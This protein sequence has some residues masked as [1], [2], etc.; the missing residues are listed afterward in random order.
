MHQNDMQNFTKSVLLLS[1]L[2]LGSLT[3]TAQGFKSYLQYDDNLD[4]LKLTT[5]E[6]ISE[7]DTDNVLLT[8]A[9]KRSSVDQTALAYWLRINRDGYSFEN[10][11]LTTT[12][13]NSAHEINALSICQDEDGNML[14]AGSS[15]QQPGVPGRERTLHSIKANGKLNWSIGQ[16]EHDFVSVIWDNANAR[17]V[18]LS[19][20]DDNLNPTTDIMIS[21]WDASGTL[22]NHQTLETPTQDDAVK[23]IAVN[24]GY[25]VVANS[26]VANQS[27]I[28][29]ARFDT[30]LN[31][32]NAT[33]YVVTDFVHDIQDLVYDG[34]ETLMI[35]GTAT[36]PASNKTFGFLMGINSDDDPIFDYT[37][38]LGASEQVSFSGL[39]H[40]QTNVDGR[41]SGYLISGSYHD[42]ATPDERRSLVFNLRPDG[43]LVWARTYSVFPTISDQ[44]FDETLSD[45]HYLGREQEFVSAGVFHE[46]VNGVTRKKMIMF[47]RANVINGQIDVQ[48]GDC[49]EPLRLQTFSHTVAM[50]P[51]AVNLY[52]AASVS[53]PSYFEIGRAH[54]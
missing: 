17:F 22:L 33:Q 1:L 54:V 52:Q 18:A 28:L 46:T 50:N 30:D 26:D 20:N 32:L 15:A 24:G 36:D 25:A 21:Q 9:I 19:N 35:N 37:Y 27:Q 49:S 3:S 29:V 34:D 42:P 38:N 53:N 16:A 39:A 41:E 8:G 14:I 12:Q 40:Y 44:D 31:L 45:I 2:A 23:L 11:A 13:F 6:I 10:G 43:T 5:T 48:Q 7:Q 51:L 47:V 4:P